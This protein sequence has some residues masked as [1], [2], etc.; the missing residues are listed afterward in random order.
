MRFKLTLFSNNKE[1][2]MPN[3][4]SF[5]SNLSPSCIKAVCARLLNTNDSNRS[6]AKQVRI[7]ATT[8]DRLC[9]KLKSLNIKDYSEIASLSP[10]EL[11]GKFYSPATVAKLHIT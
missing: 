4:S 3:K 5:H 2:F 9:K 11:L 8:V 1:I 6:I 10:S 7:S